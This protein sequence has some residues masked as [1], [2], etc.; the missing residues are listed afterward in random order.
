MY[1]PHG[2]VLSLKWLFWSKIV[3][4]SHLAAVG[5]ENPANFQLMSLVF[6]LVPFS[7]PVLEYIWTTARIN[8]K[9]SIFAFSIGY[10][11]DLRYNMVTVGSDDSLQFFLFCFCFCFVLFCL[12]CFVFL[13]VCFVSFFCLFVFCFCLFVFVCLVFFFFFVF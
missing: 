9:F 10:I 7:V 11:G 3:I 1:G 6:L 4:S 13:F 2:R 8:F 5:Y 12:F